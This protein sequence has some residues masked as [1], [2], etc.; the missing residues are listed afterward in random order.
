MSL[1]I[2]E[3]GHKSTNR[4]IAQIKKPQIGGDLYIHSKITFIAHMYICI[5]I[6]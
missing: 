2:V 6:T 5:Y 1:R 3:Q 4:K